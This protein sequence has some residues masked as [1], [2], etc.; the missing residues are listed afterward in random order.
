MT[1]RLPDFLIA[2]I[3]KSGTSTLWVWLARHPE[4]FFSWPKE[5]HYF[6][7]DRNWEK[8]VDW[9]ASHFAEAGDARAVGEG[10][11]HYMNFRESIERIA[12]TLPDVRLLV[13]LREPAERAFS[14]Y[15]HNARRDGRETRSF[16]DAIHQELAAGPRLPGPGRVD[17]TL[18]GY[19]N[20][21]LYLQQIEMLLDRFPREAIHVVILEELSA[22]P[23]RSYS[24]ACRFL[25]IDDSVTPPADAE[26]VNAHVEIRFLAL[27][28]LLV[29]L[30]V[31]DRLGMLRQ[32]RLRRK[33]FAPH[34][35]APPEMDAGTRARLQV[36]FEPENRRLAEWLGRDLPAW[37]VVRGAPET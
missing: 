2:G 1:A 26:R 8:G 6:S 18:L 35:A 20:Q 25:G 22:D 9:Y 19:V 34:E 4:V 30:G 13:C 14:S 27:W 16:K 12:G 21:G 15:L 37:G 29:R 28:R 7:N 10:T 31:I 33:F 32:Q 24:E 23:Q 17:Y 11:P 5:L 3:Q 36:F